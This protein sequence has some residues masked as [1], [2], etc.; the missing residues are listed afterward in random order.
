M[1][2]TPSSWARPLSWVNVWRVD[3][4]TT[5][6]QRVTPR[7]LAGRRGLPD[8]PHRGYQLVQSII[9]HDKI[10]GVAIDRNLT[11]SDNFGGSVLST[12]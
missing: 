9:R 2:Q 11:K 7:L 6:L 3:P 1:V 10:D 8:I 4:T 12:S 5:T